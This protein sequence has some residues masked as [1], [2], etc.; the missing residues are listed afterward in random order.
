MTDPNAAFVGSI[1][2]HYER[3][4]GPI[5]FHGFADDLVARVPITSHMRILETACGSG[6]VTER[7]WSRLAGRGTLTATDLNEAMLDEARAKR[8]EGAGLVWRQADAT[9]LPFD[10]GSFDVVVCQFGLMFFPD[11]LAGIKEAFRALRPGGL[12]LFSVWDDIVHNRVASITRETIASFFPDDPPQFY[13]VP[14][15]LYD[16]VPIRALLASAGFEQ[17]ETETVDKVGL[18]PSA[19]EAAL[20]L[21][22]GNPIGT[23]I[24]KRRP[25]A[26]PAIQ[27]AVARN[28]AAELGDHPVRGPLRAHVVRATKPGLRA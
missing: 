8:I 4:L 18:S 19:A 13:S 3:Y 16:L 20:G 5:F 9:Q 28:L 6:I 27:E 23:E 7:L 26:L 15:G 24:R 14:F 17:V 1:P 25:E 2:S 12:Y 11:K 22:E 21:L 10:D